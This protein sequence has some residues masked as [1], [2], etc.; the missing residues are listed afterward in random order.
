MVLSSPP[1]V[2]RTIPT[3][4]SPSRDLGV[5]GATAPPRRSPVGDG[6]FAAF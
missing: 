3:A 4:S 1:P 5:R 2:P 6:Q